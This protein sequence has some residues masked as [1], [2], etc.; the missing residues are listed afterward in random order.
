MSTLGRSGELSAGASRAFLTRVVTLPVS[1]LVSLL[2][3]RVILGHESVV[4]YAAYTLIIGLVLVLPIADFGAGAAVTD[5]VAAG[6]NLT[7]ERLVGTLRSSFR[8]TYAALG[9][10]VVVAAA[11]AFAGVW[12]RILGLGVDAPVNVATGLAFITFGLSIPLSLGGRALLG[13]QRNHSLL[14]WQAAGGVVSLVVIVVASVLSAP[15]WAFAIAPGAGLIA[16]GVTTSV[17]AITRYDVPLRDAAVAALKTSASPVRIRH[18]AWPMM[19]ISVSLPLAYQTDRLVLSWVSGLV[20]VSQYS[21]AAPFYAGAMSLVAAAGVSL[22][23]AFA[24]RRHDGEAVS[25]AEFKQLL[26]KFA[27]VGVALSAAMIL[28]GP[29]LARWISHGEVHVPELTW[30]ALAF[31][32]LVH[33]LWSPCGMFLTDA[34][35]LKFQGIVSVCMLVLNVPLSIALANWLGTPGPILASGLAILA[36]FYVPGFR[37]VWRGLTHDEG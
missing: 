19:V 5:A 22:W 1:T 15:L 34:R 20:S 24:R 23:P 16:T 12:S 31:L 37:R 25:K 2:T 21:V 4:T 18:L 7:R 11:G 36:T 32:L 13:L 30:F 29:P 33:S 17:L 6:R 35:G 26:L 3:A 8:L 14:I 27:V 10:V 28:L 9:L